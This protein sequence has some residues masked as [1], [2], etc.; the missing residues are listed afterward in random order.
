MDY[1]YLKPN[2]TSE[3]L[4]NLNKEQLFVL[5][6][7]IRTFL[8]DSVSKTG[9]HLSSN[10]GVVELTVALCY[11]F[12]MDV[13][14][15]LWDVGHQCYTYKLL[16]GRME[17]FSKLRAK[18]GI[19]GFPSPEESKY[20]AFIAGHG[21]TSLSAAIG[22]ATAKKMKNEPGWV[23]AIVG[24]GAFTGGM[25][26]EGLN[27]IT[28]KLDNLIIILND[29]KMSISKN[30]GAVSNYLTNLR[31]SKGYSSA[32]KQVEDILEKTPVIGHP[33]RDM[34]V[35]SKAVIRRAVYNNSTFFEDLGLQ[36]V[37]TMNG[38]N[39]AVLVNLFNNI[40]SRKGPLFIHLETTKGKGFKPAEDNP[41][42]FHGVS[43]FD[44]MHI[45]DPDNTPPDSF[46]N[47]MGHKLVQLA[48]QDESITAITA[49]MKYGTGLQFFYKQ[50]KNRFFDVGMA[51]QHAVTFAAGLANRGIKPVVALY[52]T[53][54]QR[55]YDQIIH[56]VMLQNANVLFAIDRAGLVPGD[57]ETHQGIYDVAFLSEIRD[58]VI[59]SP[60]NYEELEYWFEKLITSYDT[61]RAIRYPRG[62]ETE[63]L[64]TYKCTGNLYDKIYDT[65]SA[66]K[67]FVTYGKE[68]EE[69]LKAC[70]LAEQEDVKVDAFKLLQI[71]PIP[72]GFVAK[73]L[74]YETIVFAEEGIENGGVGQRLAYTLLENGFSGKYHIV[75]VPNRK[76]D[77]ATVNEL[78]VD[79]GLDANA[80]VTTIK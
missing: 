8:I 66:K 80:L 40:Q 68:A 27:N 54:L 45:T 77:H 26:Y 76:I 53:F 65:D 16:T 11:V 17:Q 5:C 72:D 48:E 33:L 71:N 25:I 57:G 70:K 61:P 46:S 15:I 32:K 59:M 37:G 3:D 1:Q 39:I 67:A 47:I 38:N 42:A 20:D 49:A 75:A 28:E 2:L 74:Q 36:Y 21:N 51:E 9:G 60:S 18:G 44:Y 78:L 24:D 43:T 55:A 14:S 79:F 31:N 30:V 35:A 10:L 4:K 34:I 19:A 69:V 41:G 58:L 22:I 62:G 63:L 52:S 12:D 73:L 29:N 13:D 50:F 6:Q 56:D 64:S 7:E 23:V